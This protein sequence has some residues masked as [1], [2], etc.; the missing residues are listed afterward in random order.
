META[1]EGRRDLRRPRR[2]R[3]YDRAPRQV[4]AVGACLLGRHP[5]RRGDLLLSAYAGGL[6]KWTTKRNTT[7]RP[8]TGVY[9]SMNIEEWRIEK[10]A[11]LGYM[12]ALCDIGIISRKSKHWI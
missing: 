4:R 6:T 1:G 9:G 5:S 8:P 2:G 3:R 12:A 11:E 10:A 7:M